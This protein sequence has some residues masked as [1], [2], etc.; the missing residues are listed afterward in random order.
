[1][2]E[3]SHA[4]ASLYLYP[5]GLHRDKR[6]LEQEE[7]AR[8]ILAKRSPLVEP[9]RKEP[10]SLAAALASSVGVQR[11]SSGAPPVSSGFFSGGTANTMR[12]VTSDAST[13]SFLGRRERAKVLS[14][15][16]TRAGIPL[17][18]RQVPPSTG[19]TMT[20][21]NAPPGPGPVPEPW[22]TGSDSSSPI[23]PAADRRS[24]EM[25]EQRRADLWSKRM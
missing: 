25:T 5:S 8:K 4:T 6:R 17:A 19:T 7:R 13:S 15:K 3:G 12:P 21:S 20:G 18:P 10:I 23:R 2:N 16:S 14:S 24:V 22:P 1:M 11:Q 9:R